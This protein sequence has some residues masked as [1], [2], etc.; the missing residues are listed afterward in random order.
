MTTGPTRHGRPAPEPARAPSPCPRDP[1][2]REGPRWA[3]AEPILAR[4]RNPAPPE[5]F[6]IH[7]GTRADYDALAR[8]HYRAAHPATL[9]HILRATD[10]DT[11]APAAVLTVSMPTRNGAWRALAWPGDYDT[12][13]R[14]ANLRRLN[15]QVRCLSRVIVHPRHR[16]RGLATALVRRYLE[17][18]LTARTEAL[19][20]MGPFAPFFAAAGMTP[21]PVPPAPRD[22]RL[23]ASLRRARHRPEDLLLPRALGAPVLA[24]LRRWAND[25]GATRPLLRAPVRRLACAAAFALAARPT[26]YTH[27]ARAPLSPRHP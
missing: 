18:P 4:F 6:L 22:T 20:A 27:D 15:A 7:P 23:R 3:R 2:P 26:A 10:P 8:F 19:A 17:H 21:R 11:G 14:A 16:A 9:V 12:P 5:P 25:S 1:S 13:D 24:E